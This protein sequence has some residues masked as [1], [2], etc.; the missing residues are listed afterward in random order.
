MKAKELMIGVWVQCTYWPNPHILQVYELKRVGDDELKIVVVED[1]L[2]LVFQEKYIEPISL[3]KE[4]LEKNGFSYRKCEGGAEEW[5]I[6]DD[7][8]DIVVYEW[9][10]S[11]WVFRYEGCEMNTPHEQRTFSYVHNLQHALK[12]CGVDKK[13]VL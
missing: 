5:W 7:Y 9:S 11:I 6:E 10:D 8:Y 4:I 12:D 13:I 1:A 2:P 3:T